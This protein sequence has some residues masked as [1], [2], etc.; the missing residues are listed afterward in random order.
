MKKKIMI[1]SFFFALLLGVFSPILSHNALAYDGGLLEGKTMIL[2]DNYNLA[3]TNKTEAT[4]NDEGTSVSLGYTGNSNDTLYYKFSS[5]VK[6]GYVYIKATGT[7]TVRLYNSVGTQIVSFPNLPQGLNDISDVSNVYGIAITNQSSSSNVIL[8]EFDAF[9]SVPDTVAPS[10][11]SSL[12]YIVN[13]DS[14]SFSWTNPS[15]GDFNG[16]KVYKDGSYLATVDKTQN[17]YI[18]SGLVPNTSYSFRFVSVDTSGNES[19]GVTQIVSTSQ[20]PTKIPPAN[21]TGL[22]ADIGSNSVVLNWINPSDADLAGFK[23]YK[24]EELIASTDVTNSY[25]V[26]GLEPL[27]QYVFKVIA[28]DVDGNLSAPSTLTITTEEFQDTDPPAVPKGLVVEEGN[29]AL[30][31]SWLRNTDVDLAGYNVYVNGLKVNDSLVKNPF[32]TVTDLA[33]GEAYTVQI[34]AV[35]T[36]GNESTKTASTS[37]TPSV[38]KMPLIDTDYTLSDV[39][40]GIANWFSEYW[41]LLAFAVSIPLSFY[42]AA[43]VK[44]LFLD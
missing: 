17:T 32:Y 19:V 40:E 43:R 31:L 39:A 25:T 21:V 6:V 20:D 35:D 11:I 1:F 24:G 37:G 30:F 7:Y 10:N 33:N 13:A 5:S 15:D 2:S 23:I 29:G 4:D 42:I 36:K 16:V 18:A 14:S 38:L 3:G 34:T 22:T 27:T 26:T 41:L 44:L 8:S 28:Y 9:E 12:N